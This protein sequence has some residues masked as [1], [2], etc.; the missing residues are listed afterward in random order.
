MNDPRPAVERIVKPRKLGGAHYPI[1]AIAGQQVLLESGETFSFEDMPQL[2]RTQ[3]SSIVVCQSFGGIIK[4]LDEQYANDPLWQFQARPVER[5]SFAPNRKTSRVRPQKECVINYFGFKSQSH[6]KGEKG[7]YHYPLVP[8]TFCLKT[9]G[10]L[11]RGFPNETTAIIQLMKWAKE[12]RSF[13][14]ANDMKLSPN[15]GGLGAKFLRDPRF[16]PEPRRKVPDRT[17]DMTRNL[18]PGNYY[19]LYAAEEGKGVHNAAYLD[20]RS[21]HHYAAKSVK[22]PNANSLRWRGRYKTLKDRSYAKAGTPKFERLIKEYGLFYLAIETPRWQPGQF[23]LPMSEGPNGYKRGFF[24]SNEIAYLLKTGVRIRHIIACWT[25]PDIDAGLNKYARWAETQIA[26]S[27]ETRKPWLKPTLLSTYGVLASKPRKYEYGFKQCDGGEPKQYPVGNSLL[28][29][30]ATVS[31]KKVGAAMANIIHRGLIEA[32]TR[33]FSLEFASEL[34]AKGHVILAIYADSIFVEDGAGLPL[35]PEPWR[36]QD[37]LTSLRF[38]S[39]THFTSAQISK[40][41]GVPLALRDRGKLPPRP[42][43]KKKATT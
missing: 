18:L 21:A 3:P 13:L 24:Y 27:L 17:N 22:F 16:Y 26:S 23:P 11:R 15:T 9:I 12:V 37:F 38:E 1:I 6:K 39:S 31:K 30:Q 43:P 5:H 2:F 19:K 35:L 32:Q 40:Q 7:R 10:E 8:D 42:K 36:V 41:P 33:L 20:Q 34:S 28:D 4:Y 14:I 29:V 25:S